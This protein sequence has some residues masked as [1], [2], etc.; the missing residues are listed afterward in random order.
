MAL[1]KFKCTA[2]EKQFEAGDWLCKTG[3][4][5]VVDKVRYFMDDAPTVPD[6]DGR[7][8]KKDSMTQILN[9]PPEKYVSDG[10]GGQKC[11]PGG[12]IFFVRGIYETS[13][14]EIQFHLN[15]HRGLCSEERWKEVYLDKE[16]KLELRNLE[17]AAREQRIQQRE[18]ELLNKVQTGAR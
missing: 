13:D 3:A 9:M 5:H 7:I 18:N 15:G 10:N 4:K 17:L 8:R 11:I 1:Q 6:G 14:P 2:C 12:S 16:E